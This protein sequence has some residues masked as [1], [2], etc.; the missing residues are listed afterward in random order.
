[1]DAPSIRLAQPQDQAAV[2]QLA[3]AG[4]E[5]RVPAAGC[6]ARNSRRESRAAAPRSREPANGM[7]RSARTT[8]VPDS[9]VIFD[10]LR[11]HARQRDDDDDFA[12]V[13]EHVDRRLPHRAASARTRSGGR[14]AGACARPARAARRPA[15]TSSRSDY[16]MTYA[17][18]VL[19]VCLDPCEQCGQIHRARLPRDLASVPET[20]SASECRGCRSARRCPAPPRC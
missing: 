7:R 19:G 4:F 8:S 17:L 6:A 10:A 3:R 13:L 16:V 2:G 18:I 1:M 15:P 11:R 20:R 5:P 9:V 14:T 12:F